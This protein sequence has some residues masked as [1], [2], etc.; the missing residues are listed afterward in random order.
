MKK[1]I[2]QYTSDK[3]IKNEKVNAFFCCSILK[4]QFNTDILGENGTCISNAVS[5]S[6]RKCSI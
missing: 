2:V 5:L 1:S 3:V 6:S 4:H